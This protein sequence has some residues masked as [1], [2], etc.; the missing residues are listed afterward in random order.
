MELL[1]IDKASYED[2]QEIINFLNIV[3]GES[4]Y[5]T[6]GLNEFPISL[7]DEINIIKECSEMNKSLMLIAK[8]DSKIVSQLFLD[9]PTLSRLSHI[10]HLGITVSK[11]HWGKN[12]GQKMLKTSIIWA[13]EK[14]LTK[15]QLQVRTD[16]LRAINLYKKLNFKIE[17]TIR[18]SLKINNLFYDEYLM[19]LDLIDSKDL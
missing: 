14:Q 2:A 7:E 5:L 3:G 17:G 16:N 9:I 11:Y 12:L 10:G 1:H 6:F 18:K 13:K 19:G 15:L 4:E 8:I